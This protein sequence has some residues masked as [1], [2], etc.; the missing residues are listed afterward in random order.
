MRRRAFIT[1]LGSGTPRT[2]AMTV[3]SCSM[4][5]HVAAFDASK[6]L[7]LR[8]FVTER[9]RCLILAARPIASAAL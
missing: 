5:P 8:R 9:Q 6:S 7:T 2:T 3:L 1:L 4:A